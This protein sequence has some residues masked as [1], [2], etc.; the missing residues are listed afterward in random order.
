MIGQVQNTGGK[1]G[2]YTKDFLVASFANLL[3]F[4]NVN[5][6]NLLPLY[7]RDL[8]GTEAQIGGIM[9]MY[10]VAAILMQP[11][12]GVAIDRLGRRWFMVVGAASALFASL[13]FGFSKH[14]GAHF[15]FLRF[16]QGVG[17]SAFFIANFTFIAELAP[18]GRRAEA[19]GVFGISGLVTIALAPATG[20][21][22][23]EAFGYRPFFFITATLAAVAL[24]VSLSLRDP[25]RGRALTPE[26][27]F[28]R[29]FSRRRLLVPILVSF[30][31]GVGLG[32]VF[33]FLPPY[34]KALALGRIGPFYI[35]YTLAAIGVRFFGGRLSDRFGRRR[36]I[37]PGLI[38]QAVG[39][40]W[41][42]YPHPWFALR[43][44]GLLIGGAHGFLYPALSALVVDLG[45]D[46]GRGRVLGVFSAAVLCGSAFGSLTFG[47][48]AHF[49]GFPAIFLLAAGIILLGFVA[50]SLWGEA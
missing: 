6:F 48:V 10:Q 46:G 21:L 47:V 42:S 12:A 49:L 14:L 3:F 38:L 34:A 26:L 50:F 5:A 2:L 35:F 19:M 41:L 36:V 11:L 9:G 30:S 40:L 25:E 16:L 32:T 44:I 23:I 15:F 22:I 8:G 24:G 18:P 4:S 27:A 39:S 43:V 33:V 28:D 1:P 31:F 20:E 37:L 13:A 17:Y 29:F 45:G 7:I